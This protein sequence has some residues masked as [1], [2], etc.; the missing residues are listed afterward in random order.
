MFRA[1]FDRADLSAHEL[2]A[3]RGL[4]SQVRW[5]AD[6]QPER[7]PPSKKVEETSS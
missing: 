1:V 7:L 3:L 2:S 5:A 6:Q 4:A